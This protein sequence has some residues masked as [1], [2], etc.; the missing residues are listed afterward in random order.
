VV[1][2]G[3]LTDAFYFI[4]QAALSAVVMVAVAG[5]IDFHEFWVAWKL[6]KKD[7]FVMF[8]TLVFT[9]VFDT[10]IGLGVGIG[11]SIVMLLKDLAYSLESKPIS[12]AFAFEGVE[13]I[14]LNSNLVFVSSSTIKDTLINEVRIRNVAEAAP[15]SRYLCIIDMCMD[16]T[17]LSVVLCRSLRNTR[18]SAR[19]C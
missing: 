6:S 13:I 5:L 10:E 14:R 3:T 8:T 12:K 16:L 19:W 1:A 7:F 4:P 2:L 15:S 17:L 11:L 9:F 18:T